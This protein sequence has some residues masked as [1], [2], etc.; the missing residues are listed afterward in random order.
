MSIPEIITTLKDIALGAAAITTAIVAYKGLE[1]WQAELKGKANF[2]V[3]RS[4]IKSIYRLRDEIVYCRSPFIPG[5]EFPEDYRGGLGNHTADE[6][7]QAYAHIF[8]KRWE[9]V[10]EAIQGFDAAVL[11]AEALWGNQIKQ[12]ALILRQHVRELQVATESL[13]NDKYSGGADFKA[14]REF[15][16]S[17]REKVFASP[18][19][20]DNTLSN[21]INSAIEQLENEIQPHLSRS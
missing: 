4:L 21:N 12:S 11:E 16:V 2:D 14:D 1:K 20:T 13:I 18:S 6:E 8:S 17:T 5:S 7:G 15:G 10:S 9:P 3:A 19:A